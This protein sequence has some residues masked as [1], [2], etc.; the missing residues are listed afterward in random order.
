MLD[1]GIDFIKDLS[2]KGY[3]SFIVG[4][5]VRDSIIGKAPNDIDILTNCPTSDLRSNYGA[6]VVKDNGDFTNAVVE[7]NGVYMDV[8][9]FDKSVT[10]E[11]ERR[12]FTINSLLMNKDREVI[13]FVNGR[14]H[15]KGGWVVPV[16]DKPYKVIKDDPI[17]I[18]RAIRLS[19]DTGFLTDPDLDDAMEKLGRELIYMPGERVRDELFKMSKS[20][21][22]LANCINTMNKRHVL[23][24]T[25]PSIKQMQYH[26][27]HPNHHPEGNVFEHTMMALSVYDYKEKVTN[28]S[29]LF[30]DIGKINTEQDLSYVGH[31][32][33]GPKLIEDTIKHRL[34]LSKSVTD[35]LSYVAEN[36]MLAKVVK[37]PSK[38][39]DLLSHDSWDILK[40]VVIADE[41]CRGGIQ[42][43]ILKYR[44]TSMEETK[45]NWENRQKGETMINGNRVMDVCEIDSG[46]LVGAIKER[47]NSWIINNDVIWEEETEKV[48]E[49]LLEIKREITNGN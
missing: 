10:D 36:H 9:V 6:I 30:H 49:R 2:S 26:N 15:I 34:S 33:T 44:F 1:R 24:F 21:S 7:Y 20:G 5:A 28:L 41:S 8:S 47:I 16:D 22:L 46:P 12:D 38:I 29:I 3:L 13:D 18:L 35:T 19:C 14:E 23:K 27:H 25:L 37:K 42:P 39:Y 31:D 11:L 45:E 32:Y 48:N 17:R 43:D 4:G 40:K